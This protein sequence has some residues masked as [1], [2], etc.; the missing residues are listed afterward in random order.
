MITYDCQSMSTVTQDPRAWVPGLSDEGEAGAYVAATV[1][2]AI[3]PDADEA[4]I[5][6]AFVDNVVW[7]N[8]QHDDYAVRNILFFYEPAEV[9]EFTYEEFDWTSWSSWNKGRS[10]AADRAYN[11]VHPSAAYRSLYRVGL[12]YP[13]LVSQD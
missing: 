7:G 13:G 12:A 4:R 6:D 2:Q 10:Y 5:L 9:P 1:K 8:I 11:Y 3:Y